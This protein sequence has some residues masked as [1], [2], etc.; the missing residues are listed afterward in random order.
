MANRISLWLN[1]QRYAILMLLSA[2]LIAGAAY[3][4]YTLFWLFSL[5]ALSASVYLSVF[6]L[7]AMGQ[8]GKKRVL[9]KRAHQRM[10]QGTF[11]KEQLIK[12]CTDPCWRLVV[13]EILRRNGCSRDQAKAHVRAWSKEAKAFKEQLVIVNREGNVVYTSKHGNTQETQMRQPSNLT[14]DPPRSVVNKT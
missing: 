2:G 13:S 12:Y 11:E 4:L 14:N 7:R 9:T 6:G 3:Y 5:I 1:Y 8:F 10:A